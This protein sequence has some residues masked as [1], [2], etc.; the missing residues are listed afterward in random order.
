MI[1][2]W[3]KIFLLVVFSLL[4]IPLA[5]RVPWVDWKIDLRWVQSK[6][7]CHYCSHPL[8]TAHDGLE[9]I[10]HCS[11]CK[12]KISDLNYKR[13]VVGVYENPYKHGYDPEIHGGNKHIS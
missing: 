10:V 6:D 3:L 4:S 12:F 7:I 11:H 2:L 9:T 1:V 5:L 8:I 13:H